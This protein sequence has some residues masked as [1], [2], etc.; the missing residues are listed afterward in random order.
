V[1]QAPRLDRRAVERQV[2]ERLIHWRSM[3]TGETADGRELFREVLRGPIRFTP[4]LDARAYHFV[5]EV[6]LGRLFS[7]IVSLAPFVASPT[8]F[9]PVFWP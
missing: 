8:G 2:R 1:Q 7:G 9:E 6:E 5:G 4:D 3:L